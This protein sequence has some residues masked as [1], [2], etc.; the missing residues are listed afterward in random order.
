MGKRKCCQH[1]CKDK[2]IYDIIV[3]GLGPAGC[4]ITNRMAASGYSVLALEAGVNRNELPFVKD[5]AGTN[6]GLVGQ[7]PAVSYSYVTLPEEYN[8][9]VYYTR[10]GRAWGGGGVK[11]FLNAVRSSPKLHEE[12]AAKAGDAWNYENSL[13][14]YKAIEDYSAGGPLR[15]TSG[16]IHIFQNPSRDTAG[17]VFSDLKP[18][19]VAQLGG[20]GDAGIPVVDDFN[21]GFDNCVY[22]NNQQFKK[23]GDE[24]VFERSFG[25]N[26]LIA[27]IVDD[28]GFGLAYSKL[29]V[30]SKATVEKLLFKKECHCGEAKHKAIGVEVSVND[31][32]E[33][34]YAKCKVIL[35]A[36]ALSTPSIA[37]RSGIGDYDHLK[38]VGVKCRVYN[39]PN[40][41]KNLQTHAGP[42][43]VIDIGPGKNGFAE[44]GFGVYASLLPA[45]T[46][47][48]LQMISTGGLS[49]PPDVADILG[50]A[51]IN[52][53]TFLSW[54]VHP[55]AR[56]EVRLTNTDTYSR[57]TV[58]FNFL[59]NAHDRAMAFEAL[60]YIKRVVDA[61]GAP[62][63]MVYPPDSAI[64]ANDDDLLPY[65]TSQLSIT[66]HASGT[67]PFGP[68]SEGGVVDGDLHVHGVSNLMVAD[69]SVYHQLPDGNTCLPSYYVGAQ[70]V[71]IL[72]GTQA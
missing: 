19:L 25:G 35:C 26:E 36:G 56:G 63:S 41:G 58:V 57:P 17:S 16:P 20:G 21:A 55:Q 13:P 52:Y 14:L 54:N 71:R 38:D 27:P 42:T 66:D 23:V 18:H 45:E 39:N 62:Y 8:N 43:A 2:R 10:V 44:A 49:I 70:A 5:A 9:G 4:Y 37:M 32:C 34:Y 67:M 50:E 12:F 11:N 24:F 51:G 15:G 46:Q 40:V 29:R 22:T 7:H 3:V 60:R 72:G 53:L 68:E 65:V 48:H 30:I 1:P 69:D 28:K 59:Q 6:F 61:A 64:T 33:R 47:R 31:H